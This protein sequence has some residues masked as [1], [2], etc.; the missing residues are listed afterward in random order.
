MAGG[1]V[2]EA[3]VAQPHQQPGIAA[4]VTLEKHIVIL[5]WGDM[6]KKIGGLITQSTNYITL[7]FS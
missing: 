2:F 1:L 6:R 4:V 3:R 5:L 7:L